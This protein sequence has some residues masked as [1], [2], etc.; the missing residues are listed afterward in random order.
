MACWVAY[1]TSR[2]P[3]ADALV[4]DCDAVLAMTPPAHEHACVHTVRPLDAVYFMV[5]TLATIGYGDIV[6]SN[7][8]SRL[9]TGLVAVCGLSLFSSLLDVWGAWRVRLVGDEHKDTAS[10]REM[11][12]LLAV[13]SLLLG[14][15]IAGYMHFEALGPGDALYLSM[16]TL[17]TV[18]YGD[19]KPLSDAGKVFTMVFALCGVSVFGYLTSVISDAIFPDSETSIGLGGSEWEWGLS[20]W[21]RILG[22]NSPYWEY[23]LRS[24]SRRRQLLLVT[25]VLVTSAAGFIRVYEPQLGPIDALYWTIVTLTTIGYGDLTP[26]SPQGRA[27]QMVLVIVGLGLFSTFTDIAG[28]WY[29]MLPFKAHSRV[30]TSLAFVLVLGSGVCLFAIVE[31]VSLLDALHWALVSVTSVGYG[32]LFPRTQLGKMLTCVYAVMSVSVAG[33]FL[34]I[35]GDAVQNSFLAVWDET[36]EHLR[37]ALYDAKTAAGMSPLK[38][39]GTFRGVPK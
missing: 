10:W 39:Q 22:R 38:Q 37:H 19:L 35:L 18:G 11:A 8:H 17:T 32:D 24:W 14:V 23:S 9:L 33:R 6:P 28:E 5:I 3:Y 31:G 25:V 20:G 26:L 7:D 34:S 27:M 16:A 21:D 1:S 30:Q 15:G 13:M 12:W 29:K 2:S 4:R 36:Q